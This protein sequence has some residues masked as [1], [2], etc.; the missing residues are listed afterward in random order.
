MKKELIDKLFNEFEKDKDTIKQNLLM[1]LDTIVLESSNEYGK[2][3][4]TIKYERKLENE[5]IDKNV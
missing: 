2:L 4:L 5:K 1:A 3:T